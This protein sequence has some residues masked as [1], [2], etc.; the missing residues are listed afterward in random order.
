MKACTAFPPIRDDLTDED[1]KRLGFRPGPSSPLF[2]VRPAG[3]DPDGAAAHTLGAAATRPPACRLSRLMALPRPALSALCAAALAVL[4]GCGGGGGVSA[5]ATGAELYREYACAGCHSLSGSD[6]T[7]PTFKG[8]AGSTVTL[9]DGTQVQ[10][11]AAY[12][13]RAIV[14]PDA[15]VSEGYSPGL[16]TAS[17]DNFDLASRPEDVRKLVEFIQGVE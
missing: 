12:L 17:I 2:G 3:S 7:G 4:A 16:M 8:L 6:G 5:D 9:E 1:L 15:Q 13:E 14:D 11:D 10:A